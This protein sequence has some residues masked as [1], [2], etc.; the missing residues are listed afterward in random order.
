MMKKKGYIGSM[1]VVW[2]DDRLKTR[3]I[4]TAICP[5]VPA[6]SRLKFEELL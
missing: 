4:K 6:C 2:P 5:P 1:E 3:A